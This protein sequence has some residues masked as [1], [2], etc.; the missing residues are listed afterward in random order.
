MTSPWDVSTFGA[1]ALAWSPGLD[2]QSDG[3]C[4]QVDPGLFHTERVGE[5]ARVN[6]A[7]RVCNGVPDKGIEPCPVLDKCLTWALDIGD[8]FAVLGGTSPRQRQRM[9]TEARRANGGRVRCRVCRCL[10]TATAVQQLDCS[11]ACRLESRRRRG[12]R[13]G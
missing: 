10:Y 7:K 2:W 3:L 6:S 4:R 9:R 11:E 1:E 5:Q 13:A 12:R 8:G